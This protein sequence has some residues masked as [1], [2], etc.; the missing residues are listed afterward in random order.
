MALLV[1][2]PVDGIA[3]YTGWVLFD[4]GLCAKTF[5]DVVAQMI[6]VVGRVGD[7]MANAGQAFDQTAGL[8]TITPLA[9]RD[10]EP[11]RQAKRIDSDV[12][13]GGQAAFGATDTGSLKPP[14]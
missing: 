1:E 8:R 12:D 2:R 7:H 13:F 3:R 14:F 11:D 4:V 6:G 10:R 5:G 9:G